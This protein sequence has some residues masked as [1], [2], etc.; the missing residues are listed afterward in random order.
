MPWEPSSVYHDT[1]NSEQQDMT[2]AP[3]PRGLSPEDAGARVVPPESVGICSS[4][5]PLAPTLGACHQ[6]S[7]GTSKPQAVLYLSKIAALFSR[8]TL[9]LTV[10]LPPTLP[11]V[12]RLVKS[13][14]SLTMPLAPVPCS[15]A[16]SYADRTV[17]SAEFSEPSQM[18]Q[19]SAIL[20]GQTN[21]SRQVMGDRTVVRSSSSSRNMATRVP[22]THRGIGRNAQA[23]GRT[24]QVSVLPLDGFHCS[25][26]YDTRSLSDALSDDDELTSRMR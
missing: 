1:C 2:E 26:W 3:C 19:C 12:L 6:D 22:C 8:Y 7:P 13:S 4:G 9:R 25:H 11:S 10:F 15:A 24:R 23:E 20:S 16:V 5:N 14:P 18:V 17:G 21:M